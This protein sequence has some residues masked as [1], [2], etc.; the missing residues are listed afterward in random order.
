[1]SGR[2][3]ASGGA[4]SELDGFL[5]ELTERPRPRVCEP[6]QSKELTREMASAGIFSWRVENQTAPSIA[7]HAP[8]KA[9]MA[10]QAFGPPRSRFATY[11]PRTSSAE[12][13]V[14]WK[15]PK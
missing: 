10:P 3:L 5:L 14:S 4:G 1:V 11:G 15:T 2:I 7:K 12:K 6:N 8:S 13:Y 9:R